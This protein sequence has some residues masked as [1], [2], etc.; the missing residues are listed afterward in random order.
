MDFNNQGKI[1]IE[2][3]NYGII[4]YYPKSNKILIGKKNKW[5]EGG[6]YWIRNTLLKKQI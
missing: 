1:N 4:D 3:T 5:I 2:P 6:L